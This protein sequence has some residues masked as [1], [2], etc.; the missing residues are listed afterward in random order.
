LLNAEQ[1]GTLAVVEPDKLLVTASLATRPELAVV[2]QQER[3]YALSIIDS[4]E[5]GFYFT[6]I[7]GVFLIGTIAFLMGNYIVAPILL[8]SSTAKSIT[9]TQDYTQRVNIDRVDEI[10]QLS[11][12][13]NQMIQG[14]QQMI[15]QLKEES[16]NK[17]KLLK[18]QSRSEMLEDLSNKLSKYL[19]PQI[20]QS[21]FSGDKDVTLSSSRKKLTVFFSDIVDFTTITDQMESEDLTQL[22]N[23]YLN[24]MTNIA[25]DY[26]AT[27]DKYIGDSIMIFFGDP[28]TL[29]VAE[30]ARQCVNMALEMQ[31]RVA[32][33]QID[34]RDAGYIKPFSLRY[35]IHTGYCTVGNFGSENRMD[36][37][38]IGSTVNLA[39]RIETTAEPGCVYISEDTFLL[40]KGSFL[41]EPVSTVIPK[42]FSQPVQLYKVLGPTDVEQ[43]INIENQGFKLKYSPGD[44]DPEQKNE[45]SKTLKGILDDLN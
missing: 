25:L 1:L 37:T 27:V 32:Q 33:L 44:I 14:M 13:F 6:L 21:I 19:S 40:T 29:G 20:Y 9:K 30:D 15:E 8:L 4:I 28:H 41:C 11:S 38:I 45:L 36:Y 7:V 17:I 18:E 5:Q 34:W 22:L 39:S 43:G 31:K 16:E 42:G 26:G 12:A 10:G 2:L 23:Q 3:S 35:G 24:D